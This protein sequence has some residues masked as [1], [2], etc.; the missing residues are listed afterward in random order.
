MSSDDLYVN[1]GASYD[2]DFTGIS[3][4]PAERV[5]EE[6]KVKAIIAASYPVMAQVADWFHEEAMAAMDISNINLESKVPVEAQVLAFQLYQTKMI[7]KAKEFA[8]YR[9]EKDD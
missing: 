8:D 5:E 1:D 3:D 6:A 7:E 9:S 2:T 4:M